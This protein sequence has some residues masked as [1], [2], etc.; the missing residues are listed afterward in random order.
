M[1]GSDKVWYKENP[2]FV[3]TRGLFFKQHLKTNNW[4]VHSFMNPIDTK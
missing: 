4:V 1:G 3:S 2:Y